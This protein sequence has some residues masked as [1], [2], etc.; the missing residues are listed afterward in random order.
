MLGEAPDGVSHQIRVF[1]LELK[2][3]SQTPGEVYLFDAQP[4]D[5]PTIWETLRD[6]VGT[7]TYRIRVR[8]HDTDGKI[9][10]VA[11]TT[12]AVKAIGAP[13]HLA[14]T[15]AAAPSTTDLAAIITSTL[16][17][18]QTI[19][20]QALEKLAPKQS[21]SD[22]TELVTALDTLDKMRNRGQ[23]EA[24][25]APAGD[26][27]DMFRAGIE[28]AREIGAPGEKSWTDVL[29]AAL[30]SPFVSEMVK[31]LQAR[32]TAP[33]VAGTAPA[34]AA[35]PIVQ[36]YL[37]EILEEVGRFAQR[38]QDV[39]I[40]SDFV[41]ENTPPAMLERLVADDALFAQLQ[42]LPTVQAYHGYFAALRAD[43]KD[44]MMHGG[45]APDDDDAQHDTR[46]PAARDP[47]DTRN[48]QADSP[49]HPPGQT[50]RPN[51]V[52]RARANGAPGAEGPRRR[53]SRAV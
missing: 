43:L 13:A 25:A 22:I 20:L 38:G 46:E 9:Y 48:P 47:R 14:T 30:E 23:P 42:A 35:T 8:R 10:Q 2:P 29:T 50:E 4:E 12:Q 44:Y 17:R 39:T 37:L 33:A 18:Q 36:Q 19:F 15:V 28:F 34:P 16:E 31:G 45:E 52:D 40:A 53:N 49:L 24:A 32:V 3:G 11:Q 1:Q 7:G 41:I 6:K 5:L 51:P 27:Q 21:S 26:S